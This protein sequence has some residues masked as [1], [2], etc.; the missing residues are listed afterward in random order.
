VESSENLN[1]PAVDTLWLWFGVLAGPIAWALDE[2]LS[3]AV[4]Q[5]AC[6]TGAFYELHIISAV[7]LLIALSGVM[8][9]R[10]QLTLV[11]QGA[12]D[13]GGS[14]RDRSWFMARFGIACS[15]GF[16]LV[17]IALAVPKMILSPCD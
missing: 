15:L 13:E 11:P 12:D 1:A 2:G 16:A 9:A 14:S 6:S 17:I 10:W 3:Y 5:H 4:T 7:C 8:V